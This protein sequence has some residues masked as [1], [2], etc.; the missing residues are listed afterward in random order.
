[1]ISNLFISSGIVLSVLAAN[2]LVTGN[3]FDSHDR[4]LKAKKEKM[5]K[6]SLKTGKSEKNFCDD[7]R[8]FNE[9][10]TVDSISA[11]YDVNV[12]PFDWVLAQERSISNTM[13]LAAT[14]CSG[15]T[16]VD[17]QGIEPPNGFLANSVIQPGENKILCQSTNGPGGGPGAN[18]AEQLFEEQIQTFATTCPGLSACCSPAFMNSTR[19]GS[20]DRTCVSTEAQPPA[21]PF[22]YIFQ[23]PSSLG[24]TAEDTANPNTKSSQINVA[25]RQ[26]RR[27]LRPMHGKGYTCL[28]GT[29]NV[30]DVDAPNAIG[31]FKQPASFDSVMRFGGGVRATIKD[32]HD[33]PF[34]SFALKVLG[35]AEME[36]GP[37][38]TL[39]GIPNKFMAPNAKAFFG[40]K[41]VFYDTSI[42]E[43]VDFTGLAFGNFNPSAPS[44]V[45]NTFI[46]S[47]S[48]GMVVG[49]DFINIASLPQF[50]T[51]NFEHTYGS[52][53]AYRLGPNKAMRYFWQPCAGELERLQ[54]AVDFDVTSITERD[55]YYKQM[56]MALDTDSPVALDSFSFC[57][58]L[59]VQENACSQSI[60]AHLQNWDVAPQ[61]VANV[62]IPKQ[63]VTYGAFCENL[64]FT[65]ARTIEDHF[66]LGSLN[67]QRTAVYAHTQ[68]YRIA[69]NCRVGEGNC[70]DNGLGLES[71]PYAYDANIPAVGFDMPSS[72]F[73]P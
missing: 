31:L 27:A 61:L 52:P 50:L 4:R 12:S 51:Q 21:C 63:Q 57:L 35:V 38:A 1:M 72:P 37:T 28:K 30:L 16:P 29:F 56:V 34:K 10:F 60:E 6:K 15:A 62:T 58:Y 44:D 9:A 55:Y 25:G 36:Y 2:S 11:P 59:Q 26:F 48:T 14:D 47:N 41:D 73:I 71:D 5:S 24:I 70:D 7:S 18:Y 32:L 49:G 20:G 23:S 8:L 33:G 67:R 53:G 64:L 43:V 69:I 40:D 22:K 54:D 39:P 66:P 3:K 42:K 17:F 65:P 46:A 13:G 45:I 19:G 68:L